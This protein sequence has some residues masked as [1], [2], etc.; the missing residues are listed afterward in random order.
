MAYPGFR[1]LGLKALSIALA[2]LIWLLV[3]GEQIVDRALRIPL[4]FIN[5]PAALEL[6][7]EPP[8]AVDVRVR[9]SS[10]ALSR[11][12]T[13]ELVAVLDMRAARPGLRLFHLTGADVRSPFGIEVV[14]I[15]PSNL[16]I[17]FEPSAS[18]MVPVVPGVEGDPADGYVTGAITADPAAVEVV[19]PAS[20]IAQLTGAIT[21]PVSIQGAR[22]SVTETVNIGVADPS[23]RLRQPAS[24][25]VRVTIAGAPVEWAIA[26][27]PIRQPTHR[28]LE[29][30]PG[31]VTVFVRGPRE[32][33]GS[34]VED[35]DASIDVEGLGP[36]LYQLPV[37]VVPPARVG[38]IKVEPPA[39]RVRLQ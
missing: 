20:A 18:K 12:Q 6:V 29:M 15:S 16:S 38:I 8:T 32:T 10:G 34:R 17:A 21:E 23:V 9:G 19:G 39:V 24:A 26:G 7:S 33:R 1:H 14:Q 5:L 31:D 27:I 3:A 11:V 4:E 37:R 30:S 25:Q 28:S 35:F 22:D 2:A 13:G 36:G